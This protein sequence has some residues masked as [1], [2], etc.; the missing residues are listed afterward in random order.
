[1]HAT[2]VLG[3]EEA[4]VALDAMLV[5]AEAKPGRPVA[6]AVVDNH[7]D[8]VCFACMAGANPALARQNA[9]KK[10]Y[11]SACMRTDSGV[12]AERT[13]AVGRTIADLGNPELVLDAGG[14]V[15]A[16]ESDGAILGGIGVSGRSSEEDEEIARA[17]R[18][19]LGKL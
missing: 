14:A 17:G 16:R 5:A 3:L 8:L 1:M 18:A 7:G 11:T 12:F 9:L 13:K 2:P 15:I 19:A 4:R 6:L 10:A